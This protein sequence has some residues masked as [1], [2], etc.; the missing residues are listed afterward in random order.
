MINHIRIN[1]PY[2]FFV[3]KNA[4]DL[5]KAFVIVPTYGNVSIGAVTTLDLNGTHQIEIPIQLPSDALQTS[6]VK[7]H[8]MAFEGIRV[9]NMPG[10]GNT[11]NKP[12]LTVIVH[13]PVGYN[14]AQNTDDPAP[15]AK[16]MTTV[17][18]DDA[19]VVDDIAPENVAFNSPYMYLSN[20]AGLNSDELEWFSGRC[21]VPVK[22]GSSLGSHSCTPAISAVRVNTGAAQQSIVQELEVYTPLNLPADAGLSY[23]DEALMEC[24]TGEYRDSQIIQGDF[25]VKVTTVYI[26]GSGNVV[27]SKNPP[28]T[29]SLPNQSSDTKP[30]SFYD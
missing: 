8:C 29:G 14:D 5:Y 17:C 19:F 21:I 12:E 26:D 11:R 20:P 28:T 7:R 13:V 9:P 15:N 18:F 30:T 25:C 1:A 16:R 23:I 27:A 2:V 22:T 4:A 24:N 10:N 3:R 6:V